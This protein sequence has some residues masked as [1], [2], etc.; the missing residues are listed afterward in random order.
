MAIEKP[1]A[2]PDMMAGALSP[3]DAIEIEIV[4]PEAV[5]VETPDG[6]VILDFDPDA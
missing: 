4:N 1:L 2:T 3:E 5:S 6:G